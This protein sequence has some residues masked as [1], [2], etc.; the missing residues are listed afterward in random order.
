[1]SEKRGTQGASPTAQ[2]TGLRRVGAVAQL[3]G[4]ST[5]TLRAWERRHAAIEPER[6]ETGLRLYSEVDVTRLRL[7]KA[8]T[9]K[10]ES[11]SVIAN[12]DATVL[13]ERLQ[14]YQQ[15]ETQFENPVK[16]PRRIGIV[17]AELA[18]QIASHSTELLPLEVVLEADSI[19]TLIEGATD[20][21][22]EML[23]LDIK[24]LGKDP[25]KR[26]A[27]CR[28]AL[29]EKPI[30]VSYTFAPRAQLN[31]AVN[32]GAHLLRLPLSLAA[33]RD[34]LNEFTRPQ[35]A[36][37]TTPAGLD[38]DQRLPRDF[39]APPAERYFTD[40]QLARLR[41]LSSSIACECPTHVSSLIS[42]LIAFE[43]YSRNCEDTNAEDEAMHQIL[44]RGTAAARSIMEEL[45]QRLCEHDQLV[46]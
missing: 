35:R 1:M 6:T 22:V 36:E 27:D 12:L 39:T 20:H 4:L 32:A 23:L 18:R 14:N 10:G 21:D 15:A 7:L 26:L 28:E 41:E 33:L 16:Q 5:H 25:R 29:G 9:D 24:S 40:D 44:E 3:T 11:I 42:G 34:Q 38:L 17:N 46:L 31:Q 2:Q 43:E 13:R 19:D 30:W 8:L 45:L 37:H